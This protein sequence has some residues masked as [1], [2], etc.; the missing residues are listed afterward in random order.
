MIDVL[1]DG[2]KFDLTKWKE[3]SKIRFTYDDEDTKAMVHK[4]KIEGCPFNVVCDIVSD[5]ML[6]YE[7][8]N[9][10]SFVIKSGAGEIEYEQE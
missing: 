9:M 3:E 5:V 6:K 1:F 7:L 8:P 10:V 4:W 2:L